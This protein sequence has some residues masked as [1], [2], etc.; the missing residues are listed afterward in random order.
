MKQLK[1]SANTHHRSGRIRRR[2]PK[3][4]WLSAICVGFFGVMGCESAPESNRL[5]QATGAASDPTHNEILFDQVH[6]FGCEIGKVV[7]TTDGMQI[8]YNEDNSAPLWKDA[9]GDTPP[10]IVTI[11]MR[12]PSGKMLAPATLRLRGAAVGA[13]LK[14]YY[15]WQPGLVTE[16]PPTGEGL[17]KAYSFDKDLPGGGLTDTLAPFNLREPLNRLNSP[18]CDGNQLVTF[19]ISMQR[20]VY[21]QS[22][23]LGLD[24]I[25]FNFEALDSCGGSPDTR[26]PAGHAEQCGVINETYIRCKDPSN[27]CVTSYEEQHVPNPAVISEPENLDSGTCVDRVK[28]K[29]ASLL[30]GFG[31]KCAGPFRQR[32][33]SSKTQELVCTFKHTH[34]AESLD[35]YWG[36]CL[37]PL[38]QGAKC[39]KRLV[40][41]CNEHECNISPNPCKSGLECVNNVCAKPKGV[42]GKS[43]DGDE[44]GDAPASDDVAMPSSVQPAASE[45]AAANPAVKPSRSQPAATEP[46]EGDPDVEPVSAQPGSDVNDR[47]ERGGDAAAGAGDDA[48]ASDRRDTDARDAGGNSEPDPDRSRDDLV[49]DGSDND[50]EWHND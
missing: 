17:E 33:Q 31:G 41:D 36:E 16:R 10:C 11:P 48:P 34:A 27:L 1:V 29:P 44:D 19:V 32:C 42:R 18:T 2:V 26:P 5:G 4:L 20:T 49:D 24:S 50:W 6:K 35:N 30:S 21:S 43:V 39:N 46:A 13:H 47:S 25:D 12:I 37:E 9:K 38:D 28:D 7:P 45:P 40:R 8:I 22:D 15:Y 3:T 23:I 14:S